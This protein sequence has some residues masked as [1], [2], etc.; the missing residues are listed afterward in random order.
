MALDPNAI[1][2]IRLGPTPSVWRP[3]PVST[4]EHVVEELPDG[5]VNLRQRPP[6]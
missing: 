6:R 1:S 4:G 2:V 3:P 5:I